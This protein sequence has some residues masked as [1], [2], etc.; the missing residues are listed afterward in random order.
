M[1]SPALLPVAALPLIF[2]GGSHVF[3]G[4]GS[5]FIIYQCY[6]QIAQMG[7]EQVCM[8]TERF[9]CFSETYE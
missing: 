2:I 1:Q 3:Y 8:S 7:C 4:I 9:F 5:H 6:L